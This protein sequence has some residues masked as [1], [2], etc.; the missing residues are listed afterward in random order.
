MPSQA[1]YALTVAFLREMNRLRITGA[2][3]LARIWKGLPGYDEA[4][5][6]AYQRL[7]EPALTSL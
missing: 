4:D 5:I 1:D 3:L 6:P 7:A 2:D